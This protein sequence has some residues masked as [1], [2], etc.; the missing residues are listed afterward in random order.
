IGFITKTFMNQMEQFAGTFL[1]KA[2]I[3][4]TYSAAYILIAGDVLYAAFK[5][6]RSGRFF[7]EKFL[8]SLATITALII[9][10]YD[11][12]IFV[13]IFY[14]IG[15]LLQN[16]AV[17]YTRKSITNLI[18]IQPQFATVIVD[19]EY[20]EMEPIQVV[21]GD[22]IIV[23]PGERIP[24]DGVVIEGEGSLDTSALTGESLHKEVHTNDQVLSGSINI[25]G[26]LKIKVTK[27]Y[28]DSMASR[29]LDMV[30]NASSLK[31]KSENYIT[32]FARYYTPT[33]VIIALILAVLLPFIID[34]YTLT[35]KNGFQESIMTALI[36]LVVS[37]P[38]ALV[39]SIPLGFF[40]GI[41]GASRQGI[42]VKGSNY[43]ETLTSVKTFVFDKTGTLTKGR[44]VV[45]EIIS[46]GDYKKEEI[47]DYAAH[48]EAN[49]PHLI[50]R[51]IVDAY[52]AE[53]IVESRIQSQK[54]NSTFGL[55]CI[56]DNKPILIGKGDY[57]SKEGLV[58]PSLDRIGTKVYIAIDGKC[59][60]C[61]LIKDEI[62]Y[63]AATA[64]TALKENGI[65][66]T[67]M[68]T[69]DADEIAEEVSAELGIDEYYA[70]M[71]PLDKVAKVTEIKNQTPVND[72]V[73]FVGDGINDAPVLSRADV[74]I[75]MGGMG[76][77]AAIQVADIVLMTDDLA[78]L[79]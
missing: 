27:I 13:I 31:S 39:I 47:L 43:L 12:A 79:T 28:Q 19:G 58:V 60:G 2:I 23:R 20:V 21:A 5:N 41:G 53:N 75:A 6:I 54:Q 25:D 69:G 45:D 32:R 52:G 67:I 51:S 26:N 10:Y 37:C 71:S 9:Q 15:E 36:F 73:V 63:N 68:L 40:G 56:V 30:E 14:K 35:W 57:L 64:I 18:D 7:D 65:S 3:Y 78:K 55:S 8:I 42:L 11:E 66:K 34:E 76:S 4:V 77:D 16:Y 46:F 59:E 72:K 74:G 50:A 48:A 17:N 70:N 33:I 1:Q 24:L 61:L 44:F 22:I 49:S 62:K 29:I 38:C